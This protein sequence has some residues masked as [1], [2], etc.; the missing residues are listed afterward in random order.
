MRFLFAELQQ[1]FADMRLLFAQVR[2]HLADV[3][4][5]RSTL[6]SLLLIVITSEY[7][8]K[9]V[10]RLFSAN[11]TNALLFPHSEKLFPHNHG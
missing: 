2:Q 8:P 10:A 7:A 4:S 3:R 11:I 5:V 9:T 1:R 6:I